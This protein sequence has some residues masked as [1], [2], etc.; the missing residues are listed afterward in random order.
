MEHP[1]ASSDTHVGAATAVNQTVSSYTDCPLAAMSFSP[2]QKWSKQD[3]N[4]QTGS[5]KIMPPG[6]KETEASFQ[7]AYC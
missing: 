7:E 5:K 2:H 1:M 6:L 4:V 3:S